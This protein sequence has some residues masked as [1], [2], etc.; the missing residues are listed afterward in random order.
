MK[1]LFFASIFLLFGVFSCDKTEESPTSGGF[2]SWVKYKVEELSAKNGESC[3]YIWV[4]VYEVQGRRYY[5][6]DFTYSS[7]S[8]CN[9]FDGYGNR[10]L[11]GVLANP[12]EAKIIET[13][14]GCVVPK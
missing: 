12:S 4:T 11:P 13:R 10:V 2:P 14:P 3:E 7:C 5:N 6:I 8:D 9:L 1:R